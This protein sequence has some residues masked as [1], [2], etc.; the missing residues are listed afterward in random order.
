VPTAEQPESRS[1]R[2][3]SPASILALSVLIA[4]ITLVFHDGGM[5]LFVVVW[6]GSFLVLTIIVTWGWVARRRAVA[7]LAAAALKGERL[8]QQSLTP[9]GVEDLVRRVLEEEARRSQGWRSL[10]R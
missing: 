2:P 10:W 4:A 9:P 5:L 6:I 1:R 8:S 7:R 3:Q